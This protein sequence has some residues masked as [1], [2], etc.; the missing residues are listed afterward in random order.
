MYSTVEG[1]LRVA[2][3]IEN[4]FKRAPLPDSCGCARLPGC[5]L[6][7]RLSLRSGAILHGTFFMVVILYV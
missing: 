4:F 3:F 5:N 6:R 1:G 2:N 7:Y